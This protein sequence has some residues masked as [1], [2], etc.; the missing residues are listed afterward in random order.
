LSFLFL[1]SATSWRRAALLEIILFIIML[2]FHEAYNA[3]L[4][5]DIVAGAVLQDDI[6]TSNSFACIKYVF[7][8]AVAFSLF[9]IL[10]L[11]EI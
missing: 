3:I 11:A 8:A 2:F 6:D 4:A 10:K 9:P 7:H 5:I 1:F